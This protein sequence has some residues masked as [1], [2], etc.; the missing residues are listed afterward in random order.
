MIGAIGSEVFKTCA[1]IVQDPQHVHAWIVQHNAMKL[2]V[3]GYSTR[4]PGRGAGNLIHGRYYSML[5]WSR[6]RDFG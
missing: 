3:C 4:T 5:S 1:A 6:P 2:R